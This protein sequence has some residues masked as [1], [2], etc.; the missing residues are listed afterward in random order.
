[1]LFNFNYYKRSLLDFGYII[2][3]VSLVYYFWNFFT[4]YPMGFMADDSYFYSQ[5]AYNIGVNKFSS[6]DGLNLTSGYHILWMIII[7]LCSLILSLFTE[8]K[9]THLF[10]H[11]V[12]YF[13]LMFFFLKKYADQVL[14]IFILTGI[15]ISGYILM[16]NLIVI[17]LLFLIYKE[18][19]N[20]QINKKFSN[21]LVLAFFLIPLA[22]IDT[23][24]LV[25][26]IPLILLITSRD[27][28]YFYLLIVLFF[29][30][31]SNFLIYHI[32]SGEFYSVSS[33][34]KMNQNITNTMEHRIVNSALYSNLVPLGWLT[35]KMRGYIIIL[36][37]LIF[38]INI[39]VFKKKQSSLFYG[40]FLG[41]YSYFFIQLFLN[42]IDTWYYSVMFACLF[43]LFK[44]S[45]HEFYLRN[46]QIF[47]FYL[48]IILLFFGKFYNSYK[49]YD[50]RVEYIKEIKQIENYLPKNSKIYQ[51]DVSGHLGFYSNIKV[52]NGD[53]RVNSF[54]YADDLLNKNLY[55]YLNKNKICYLTD[56]FTQKLGN[57]NVL[58]NQSG[59]VVKYSDVALI[60]KFNNF[61]IFKLLSCEN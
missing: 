1:M 12:V 48:F 23:V 46:S 6:W 34:V 15:I 30:L 33:Y 8:V 36:F 9:E 45:N 25:G 40:F 54:S 44:L 47:I 28:F 5:I 42:Y 16:E 55:N 51:Y 52:I 41:L 32:I 2:I 53:G 17:F 31:I 24:A 21:T 18:I 20:Y 43:I 57:E 26:F 11:V 22:R 19:I 35:L 50:Y 49:Y 56:L 10:G 7:S 59:L 29:G 14:E 13:L 61:S 3:F 27:K 4:F 38:L 60:K 39:F 37:F 58:L